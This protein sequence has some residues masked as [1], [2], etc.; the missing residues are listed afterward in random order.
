MQIPAGALARLRR[1]LLS[2]TSTHHVAHRPQ[3]QL[4]DAA[5]A[6]PPVFIIAWNQ[7]IAAA[8]RIT[9]AGATPLPV[10]QKPSNET[11]T[12]AAVVYATPRKGSAPLAS[13]PCPPMCE[14]RAGTFFRCQQ[15]LNF[16]NLDNAAVG[17]G[18]KDST[19]RG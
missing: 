6:Q 8:Q 14:P 19:T 10:F 16:A 1:L 11:R 15:I 9:S 2:R 3:R 4:V 18:K 13:T 7:S 17:S 12:H 5:R